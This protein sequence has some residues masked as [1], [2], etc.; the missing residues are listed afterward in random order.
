MGHNHYLRENKTT[1]LAFKNVH[2][3]GEIENISQCDNLFESREHRVQWE[4]P[5][6]RFRIEG[7]EP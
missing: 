3:P 1:I 7:R 4:K 2:S 5:M 6:E